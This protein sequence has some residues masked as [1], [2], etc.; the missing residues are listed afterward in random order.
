MS[1]GNHDAKHIAVPRWA[2]KLIA[3]TLII[4]CFTVIACVVCIMAILISNNEKA[5]KILENQSEV[6]AALEAK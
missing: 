4:L 6:K 5:S 3:H 1:S 2:F